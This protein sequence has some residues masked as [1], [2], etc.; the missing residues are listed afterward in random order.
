MPLKF[1]FTFLSIACFSFFSAQGSI[2]RSVFYG[3]LMGNDLQEIDKELNTMNLT[4][5]EAF[6]GA[7]LMKKSGLMPVVKEKLKL[8]KEGHK[9]L[10]L[11]IDKDSTNAEYRFLRLIIQENAP[12]IVNYNKEIKQDASY[13]RKNYDNLPANLQ[14]VIVD[15]SK[16]SKAL[17]PEDFKH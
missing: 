8:F 2:N 4:G 3:V 1:I 5:K 11:A 15:Y 10:E 7:L 12:K 14:K 13:L 6:K 16:S 17:K 9:A